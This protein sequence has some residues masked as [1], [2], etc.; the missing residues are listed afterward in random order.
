MPNR[1]RK[2]E[3]EAGLKE[4]LPYLRIAEADYT[5][6]SMLEAISDVQWLLM[7]VYHNLGMTT[8]GK[9]VYERYQ[10]S[11]T[12]L[13]TFEENP[14]DVEAEQVWALVSDVGASLVGR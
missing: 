5:R 8:E 9:N 14:V 6:L 12:K 1:L 4:A 2:F 7:V 11:T 3:A 10:A 13:R